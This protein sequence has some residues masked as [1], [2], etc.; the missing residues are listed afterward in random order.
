LSENREAM[1]QRLPMVAIPLATEGK[2]V[3]EPVAKPALGRFFVVLGTQN[4]EFYCHA[5]SGGETE[6]I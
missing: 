3:G 4:R 6:K 2:V 5:L 1:N